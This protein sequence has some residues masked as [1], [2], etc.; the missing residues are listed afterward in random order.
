MRLFS[1]VSRGR[2]HGGRPGADSSVCVLRPALSPPALLSRYNQEA[3]GPGGGL[4]RIVELL[5]QNERNRLAVENVAIAI[6]VLSENDCVACDAF[7]NH[8]ALEVL[9]HCIVRYDGSSVVTKRLCAALRALVAGSRRNGRLFEAHDGVKTLSL[10]ACSTRFQDE[11]GIA[12]DALRTLAVAMTDSVPKA[13]AARAASDGLSGGVGRVERGSS[14]RAKTPSGRAEADGEGHAPHPI[15]PVICSVTMAMDL[16]EHRVEVQEAG[17]HALRTLLTQV[18]KGKLS[19]SDLSDVVESVGAAFRLHASESSEVC[20]LSLALL[21]DVDAA[22]ESHLRVDLDL[23]CFFGSLRH[24]VSATELETGA[25]EEAGARLVTRAL[26]VTTHI[27][28]RSKE[29]QQDIVNAGAVDACLDV[30]RVFRSRADVLEAVCGL[31]H[32]LLDSPEARVL[33]EVKSQAFLLGIL[34]AISDMTQ[35]D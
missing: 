20:W 21:C 7:G 11:P 27:G 8:G 13:A 14:P 24:V 23:E 2:A 12:V 31:A 22:R 10:T 30:L 4:R 33:I 18:E 29:T 26:Q 28:W 6:A 35:S 9:L 17:L 16:H 19:T 34:T 25:A 3:R 1:T 15:S 5:R 32:G